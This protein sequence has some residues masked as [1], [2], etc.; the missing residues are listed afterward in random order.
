MIRVNEDWVIL[1]EPM[2]YMPAKDMH[3]TKQVKQ[4]DGTYTVEP[5]YKTGYGYYTSLKGAVDRIARI[6]YKK[7]LMGRET[8]LSDAIK[9]MDDT[10]AR[11]EKI[12]EGIK[13]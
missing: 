6:E 2:N 4:K 3:R 10:I 7:E 11:F 9:L 8:T 13:E 12:L 5:D 1:V